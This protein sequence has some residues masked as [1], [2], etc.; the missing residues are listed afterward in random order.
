MAFWITGIS[1]WRNLLVAQQFEA[2]GLGLVFV[3][4]G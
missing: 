3:L 1:G 4:V 2:F